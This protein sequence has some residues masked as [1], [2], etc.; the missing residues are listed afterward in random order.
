[1]VWAGAFIL[2]KAAEGAGTGLPGKGTFGGE[3]TSDSQ[4]VFP[5]YLGE[6]CEKVELACNTVWL[7]LKRKW[8][9]IEVRELSLDTG[10]PFSQ[11]R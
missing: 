5:Q 1:M 8:A 6:V 9:E 2:C 7:E 10:K 11:R 3:R 4:A